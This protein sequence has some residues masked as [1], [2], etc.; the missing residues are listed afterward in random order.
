MDFKEIRKKAIELYKNGHDI[1]EIKDIIG[2]KFDK[3]TLEEW[4][5]VDKCRK[6]QYDIS[7]LYIKQRKEK[8]Y[9][10]K[11]TLLEDL[12]EKLEKV[13]EI[14]PDD[15]DMQTKL[16]FTKISLKDIEGARKIGTNLLTRTVS[17]EILNGMSIIEEREGN[18][19]NAINMVNRILDIDS[20]NEFFRNK[21]KRLENKKINSVNNEKIDLYA[22]IASK[23]RNINKVIEEKHKK[24]TIKGKKANIDNI[25][26]QSYIEIYSEIKEIAEEILKKYPEEI[27]AREKLIKSLYVLKEYDTAQNRGEEFLK[28]NSNDE[29]IVWYMSKIARNNGY[30][31]TEKQ[32]LEK[33]IEITKNGVP[34]KAMKR[35]EKI[36]SILE[37]QNFEKQLQ[38]EINT[39][40]DRSVWIENIQKSFQ[41]GELSLEEIKEKIKEA[42]KY[43]NY[44]KSL[45]ELLDMKTMITEDYQEELQEINEYLETEY[46]ISTEE[47]NEILNA[48]TEIKN[49]IDE[50]KIIEKYYNEQKNNNG[51]DR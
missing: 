43:P 28:E 39:E 24:L 45:I 26:E 36:K 1:K 4:I 15:I 22:K 47:Y 31:N 25:T 6:Y 9:D 16:M 14:I 49:K 51:E 3:K 41:N 21:K 50:K 30:L 34:L 2:I 10:K 8:N 12:E 42:R 33:L 20:N 7:K 19:D 11:K 37:E 38:Q 35:L 44:V 27:V 40:E 32:Y 17:T 46:S 13:L 48:M 5:K 23:E 18:Y 29:I